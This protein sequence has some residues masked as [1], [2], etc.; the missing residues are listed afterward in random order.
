MAKLSRILTTL[1]A[2]SLA[3]CSLADDS[4]EMLDATQ[5]EKIAAVM[6][7]LGYRS[8]LEIADEGDPVIRSGVGGSSFSIHF[9]G[10]SEENNDQCTIL[11]FVVSYELDDELSS[12][13]MNSWNEAAMFGRAYID[14]DR[15][16]VLEWSVDMFGGVSRKNFE[17][18]FEVW[19]ET[20]GSFEDHIDF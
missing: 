3:Q 12:E 19:E 15:D 16:A 20:V 13:D 1:A 8:K 9:Y 10:C 18:A 7:D 14:D 4:V 6:Q 2:I 17:D 5:P 11:M